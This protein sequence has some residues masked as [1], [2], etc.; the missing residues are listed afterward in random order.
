M[1]KKKPSPR[2]TK[3]PSP[4]SRKK[5]YPRRPSEDPGKMTIDFHDLKRELQVV[6][7]KLQEAQKA[8]PTDPVIG[9]ILNAAKALLIHTRCQTTMLLE[10]G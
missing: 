8:F 1:T 2:S 6:V 10:L 7:G 5:P 4:R 3:K 9:D